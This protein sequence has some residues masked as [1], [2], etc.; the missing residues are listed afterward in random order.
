MLTPVYQAGARIRELRRG[1]QMSRAEL[2]VAAGVSI[3]TINRIEQGTRVGLPSL[4]AILS[5]LDPE[6]RLSDYAE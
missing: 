3:T 6:A 5:I 4:A 1:R 2:A